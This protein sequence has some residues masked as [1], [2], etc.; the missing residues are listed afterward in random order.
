[1]RILAVLFEERYQ[2]FRIIHLSCYGVIYPAKLSAT[3]KNRVVFLMNTVWMSALRISIIYVI[4]GGIWIITSDQALSYFFSDKQTLVELQ[5]I[6][7]WFFI[8]ATGLIL[9]WLVYRQLRN[10]N[11]AEERLRYAL[12]ASGDGVW[13]WDVPSSK[14]RNYK[15]LQMSGLRI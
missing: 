6:K 15:Q 1:M 9:F 4:I 2:L 10:M 8:I 13:D 14:V 3:C 12:N 7:G 5:T 11:E